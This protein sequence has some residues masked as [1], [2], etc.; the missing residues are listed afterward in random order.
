VTGS[1]AYR[2][3][4]SA[5]LRGDLPAKYT[6]I[7]PHI[8]GKRIVEF[9]AAEGVLA[10]ALAR[11]G[12]EVT[13]IEANPERYASALKLAR[14]WDV[15]HVSFVHGKIADN[16]HLLSGM[17]ALVAVRVIYYLG[18]AID[19][20]FAEVARQIPAVVLCGN[21]NRADRWRA[22]RPHEPLGDFNRY[23]AREGM[24]ELLERHGYRIA[25][26]ETDGD[27]IVVG[28]MD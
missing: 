12:R 16:L 25:E 4:E 27:E 6:R 1:L 10:L 24:R 17:D 26:E 15:H 18:D 14:L 11:Q 23:A 19:A 21:R 2:N 20:V 5:I 3:N 28:V 7:I 8:P 22:G 13:A 9:G